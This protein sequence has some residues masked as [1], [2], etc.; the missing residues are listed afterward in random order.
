MQFRQLEYV[1]AVVRYKTMHKAA[2]ELYISEDA[3]SQQI[4]ALETELGFSL[5]ERKGRLLHLSPEGEKLLPDLHLLLQAKQTLE[6]SVTEIKNPASRPLRLGITPG[7]AEMFLGVIFKQFKHIYPEAPFEIYEG[8][9]ATVVELVKTHSV[10]LALFGASDLIPLNLSNLIIKR[11][12]TTEFV[13]VASQHHSLV[14]RERISKLQLENEAIIAFAEEF[15]LRDLLEVTL[16]TRFEGNIICS[17]N[18]PVAALPLIQ[19]GT[20][21]IFLPR[22]FMGAPQMGEKLHGLRILDLAPEIRFPVY[23]AYAYHQYYFASEPL[24]TLTRII[25]DCFAQLPLTDNARL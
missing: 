25:K 24:K 22:F 6:H 7:P 11:L 19:A 12:L 5:F 8:G 14:H 16:G 20:G 4:R 10:D 23:Y 17:T 21:I 1:A 2:Q 9:T 3:I 15:L 18:N 13:A